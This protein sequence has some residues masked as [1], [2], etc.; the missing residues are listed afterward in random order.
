[1]GFSSLSNGHNYVTENKVA[2]TMISF[3]VEEPEAQRG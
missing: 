2:N 1:M 3:T